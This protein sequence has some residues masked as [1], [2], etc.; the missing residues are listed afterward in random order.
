M[1]EACPGI[2]HDGPRRELRT[3]YTGRVAK[4]LEFE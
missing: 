2:P 3:R 4:L 1:T